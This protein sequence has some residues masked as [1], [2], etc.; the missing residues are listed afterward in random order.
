MSTYVL[1]M[2]LT[3]QGIRD[4]KGAP[5]RIDAAIKAWESM[6]GT[7]QGFYMTMGAYDYVAVG[8]APN[9]VA[10]A[11]FLLGLGSQGNVTTT[12]LKAFSRHEA[13]EI[14]STLP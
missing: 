5:Q 12:T 7:M 13:T 3:D 8:D 11:A 4:I 1:L 6:G 14:I 2:K 9:D 10:A